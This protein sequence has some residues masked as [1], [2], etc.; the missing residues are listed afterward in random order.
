MARLL[1]VNL[2][3]PANV[4]YRLLSYTI[5]FSE[6]VTGF[7]ASDLL[8]KSYGN[9]SGTIVS[10]TPVSGSSG[11]SYT[12]QVRAAGQGSLSLG[13]A[14][15]IRD[16]A[17]GDLWAPGF[18][19]VSLLPGPSG[20]EQILTADYD[21]DG[22]LDLL[23]SRVFSGNT[24]GVVFFKGA[25]DGRFGAGVNVAVGNDV[26]LQIATGDISGDGI[27]DLAVLR[28]L[29]SNPG[30]EPPNT[31]LKILRGNGDGTFTQ[32]NQVSASRVTDR[33]LTLRDLNGDGRTDVMLLRRDYDDAPAAQPDG[34]SL[35]VTLADGPPGN[36]LRVALPGEARVLAVSDLNGDG[37]LDAAISTSAGYTLLFGN[38]NGTFQ[39]PVNTA[40]TG[41]ANS[42][43][44]GDLNG[45]GKIDLVIAKHQTSTIALLLG[46][47]NGTFV[48]SQELAAN[49]QN[50]INV[51]TPIYIRDMNGDG[52]AD[53][54]VA[55]PSREDSLFINNGSSFQPKQDYL[56]N[57]N[58]AIAIGDFDENGAP[59]LAYSGTSVFTQMTGTYNVSLPNNLNDFNGDGRSDILWRKASGT[60]NIWE[61]NGLVREGGGDTSSQTINSWKIQG[62]GDF[63]GDGDSDIFW[64]N[65]NGSTAIWLMNGTGDIGHRFSFAELVW[66]VQD[67]ADFNGDGTTDVLWRND[68]GTTH[69]WLMNNGINGGGDNTSVQNGTAW[70]VLATDDFNGD[71]KGDILWR[72]DDGTTNIWFMNGLQVLSTGNTFPQKDGSWTFQDVGDFNGDGM[73]DIL[74]RKTDGL[75]EIWLMGMTGREQVGGGAT[76]SQAD[77]A[78]QVQQTGD[79]NGDGKSD[80]LWRHD[81]GSTFIWLMNG[82]GEVG[83]GFT[84]AQNSTEW[85]IF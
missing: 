83:S 61:M 70:K 8:L 82:T 58:G 54:I 19:P 24:W 40:V 56:S 65:D 72:H 22:H 1:S 66:K 62:T 37:K 68:N 35:V 14:G 41:G 71:G 44:A 50:S 2:T 27:P 67:F 53:I 69:I 29:S 18:R 77:N 11:A 16:V 4:R 38:G 26:G 73:A 10:F 49:L 34:D 74:W 31:T 63:N 79:Y 52:R 42:I 32:V 5:T 80:I 17:D 3:G 12:V 6:P 76:F 43:A 59:D 85:S 9:V 33:A 20:A 60:T 47:G 48:Q 84:S 15:D 28:N 55:S 46:N 7:D 45:D 39:A 21:R 36:E 13:V 51:S 81:N 57:S 25:G 75:T 64:R 23:V 78:W 30:S